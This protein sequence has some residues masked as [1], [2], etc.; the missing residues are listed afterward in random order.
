MGC[1]LSLSRREARALQRW[2]EGAGP[3]RC[4]GKTWLQKIKN[5]SLLSVWSETSVVMPMLAVTKSTCDD[6][7]LSAKNGPLFF[8]KRLW[9]LILLIWIHDLLHPYLSLEKRLDTIYACLKSHPWPQEAIPDN[10][11]KGT[12]A[13][14]QTFQN[15]HDAIFYFQ[16]EI[17]L[18]GSTCHLFSLDH[19]ILRDSKASFWLQT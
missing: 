16:W 11:P 3:L 5:Q 10:V 7:S 15:R 12:D 18:F 6:F 1:R 13:L 2:E 17:I 8:F 4:P 9:E 14:P 19:L